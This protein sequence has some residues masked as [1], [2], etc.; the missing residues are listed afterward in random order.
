MGGI[1]P[2]HARK[3]TKRDLALYMDQHRWTHQ[4]IED[5]GDVIALTESPARKRAEAQLITAHM[6]THRRTY[7]QIAL[8]QSTL[9]LHTFAGIY[10]G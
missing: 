8:Q 1:D 3:R 6:G 2:E 4:F 10:S 7:Q 5:C 9:G